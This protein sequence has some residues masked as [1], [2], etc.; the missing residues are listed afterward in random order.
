MKNKKIIFFAV[1][2]QKD[3]IEPTGALYVKGAENIK[4]NLKKLTEFAKENNIMVVNTCDSHLEFDEEL[5]NTPDFKTTFPPHC[6]VGSEGRVFIDETRPEAYSFSLIFNIEC[7][8]PLIDLNKKD[9]VIY[10][11]KFDVFTGNPYTNKFLDLI[12]PDIVVVYGVAGDYCVDYAVKGLI[13]KGYEVFIV[14]D[15]IKAIKENPI[16]EW[17][18]LGVQMGNIEEILQFIKGSEDEN[19]I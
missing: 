8:E 16:K 15:A 11:D 12:N 13:N 3:F 4:P 5:S 7:Y 6:M 19:K 17:E 14:I 2:C 9:V 18:K 10:K 1:D